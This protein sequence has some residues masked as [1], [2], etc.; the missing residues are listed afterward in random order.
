MRRFEEPTVVGVDYPAVT[1][2]QAYYDREAKVLAVGI[3]AGNQ[4]AAPGSPTSFRVE[5]CPGE[6]EVII[7]GQPSTEWT[8]TSDG[9]MEINTTIADH[10]ILV[11]RR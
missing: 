8:R 11:R 1:V 7:D 6:C 10:S 5:M 9:A 4:T 3:C 2:R